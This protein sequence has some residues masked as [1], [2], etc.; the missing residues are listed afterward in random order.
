MDQVTDVH[1]HTITDSK[2]LQTFVEDIKKYVEKIRNDDPNYKAFKKG[3]TIALGQYGF[4]DKYK[5]KIGNSKFC[6]ENVGNC[7]DELKR[8]LAE[9]DFFNHSSDKKKNGF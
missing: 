5:C 8:E 6:L 1:G 9:Y 4:I 2:Y 3:K 7:S